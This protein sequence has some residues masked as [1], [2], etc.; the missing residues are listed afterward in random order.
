M[1]LLND[2]KKRDD[3]KHKLLNDNSDDNDDNDI[4]L[5]VSVDLHTSIR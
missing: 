4:L 2:Y 3:E 5:K 1:K